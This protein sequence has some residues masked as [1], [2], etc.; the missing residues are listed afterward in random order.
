MNPWAE[1]LKARTKRFALDVM[2]FCRTLP[3]D[4]IAREVR[5]QFSAFP[6]HPSHSYPGL[7]DNRASS[8]GTPTVKWYRL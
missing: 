5:G 3:D 4:F 8:T 1:A 6:H 2:R 7:V